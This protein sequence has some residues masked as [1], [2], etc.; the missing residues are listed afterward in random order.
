MS[1]WTPK[2]RKEVMNKP[3]TNKLLD[4]IKESYSNLKYQIENK[5]NY[6]LNAFAWGSNGAKY[7]DD[8]ILLMNKLEKLVE[9]LDIKINQLEN[10]AIAPMRENY[11]QL[12]SYYCNKT[13]DPKQ[14][15]D[16]NI[17]LIDKY[18][19]PAIEKDNRDE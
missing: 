13:N 5:P 2:K 14:C 17:E 16:F 18:Y 4:E 12:L 10:E 7:D 19:Q 3:I 8:A 15:N 9:T 6:Y 11:K 1:L